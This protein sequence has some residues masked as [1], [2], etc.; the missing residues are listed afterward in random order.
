[1]PSDKPSFSERLFKNL[2]RVFPFD[3]QTDHGGEM[4]GVFHDQ[5]VEAEHR[6]GAFDFVR[7]WAET[8]S[9]IFR[10]APREHWEIMKQ[11]FAYSFRMLRKNWG[12]SLLAILTL[13]LGIGANTAIFSVVHSVLLSPLPYAH[14]SQL[15]FVREQALKQGVDD[16]SFSVPE[17]NDFRQQ[18]QTLDALVEYHAM[19]FTLFGH[20]D[21]DRVR[22]GVVS[23]NYFDTF[24]V[25]PIMGRSF[26]AS[27]ETIGAPAVL[28]LSYDY[29]RNSFHSDPQIVGKTF[30]M[31]DRVHTVIGVLPP[32]PQYPNE[33][34]VY[35]P[36]SACPFRASKRMMEGRD[37]RMM[38]VF[39]RLKPGVTLAQAG[40]DM[41]TIAGRLQ[42]EYPQFYPAEAGYGTATTSLRSELTKDAQPTL[43]I[44]LAAAGFVLLIACANVA[45]L[46]LSRMARRER[47]L[48]VR[49]ALGAGRTR[50]LRQLLTESFVLACIG[51]GLGLLLAYDS[52]GLLAN[53]AAR[54]TPRAHEIRLDSGVLLFTLFIALGTSILFGTLSAVSSRSNLGSGLREG[55]AGAGSSHRHNL[56]RSGLIVAQVAFSFM[57]LIGAGLLLRSLYNMLQVNP[58]FVPQRVLAMKTMFNWS[59]YAKPE[60]LEL[61]AQKIIDRAKSEPGVLSVAMASGYPLEPEVVASGPVA[62][63]N[64]FSIEGREVRAG[65]AS[66][67]SNVTSASPDYF[68]TLGI[69]LVAGRE[70]QESDDAKAMPVAM[71]NETARRQLWSAEDPI[72][73]HVSFDKGEHWITIVGIAGDV[74]EFGLNQAAGAEIYLP[75]AQNSGPTTL[76]VRTAND[77]GNMGDRMRAIIHEIDS[78]TAVT[79]LRT[80]EEARSESLTAPRLTASLLGLFAAL[81]LLIAVAG[82][83]GIMAL[84][85]SQRLHEIGIR[86]ALGAQPLGI[87]RMVLSQGLLLAALGVGI[88]FLGALGL[89]NLIKS[90][91]FEV[92]PNDPVTFVGVAL[93]LLLAAAVAGYIPARRAASVDPI[94]ALRC[95]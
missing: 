63:L 56:L 55:T 85:V 37:H 84:S 87:L 11:D 46:T 28:L 74:R 90:L 10:T 43:L 54:L 5:R 88:G 59:K 93:I 20:G 36:T 15:V 32:V 33:N 83:G 89:T 60:D 65:Q 3:F 58:G 13:T 38:E 94:I 25:R 19:G 71:I 29:W 45:N 57:L 82:I 31:N 77:P 62:G 21:P 75:L 12:F 69:P 86:M 9:G 2:V 8:L 34:D 44:L 17:I 68:R 47:E 52:L 91:L 35:M 66:P 39:G 72:G 7:L 49:T 73:K 95:E 23:W 41:S 48:A 16:I 92:T 6:G 1:M 18:N 42:A 79:R 51:G 53:F 67:M 70:F 64:E 22:T 61:V 81:A 27:D 80:L 30:E 26:Q 50:L 4:A 40:A 78:Q 24:G 14:G 76:L